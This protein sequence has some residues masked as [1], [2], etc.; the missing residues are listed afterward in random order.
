MAQS[1]ETSERGTEYAQEYRVCRAPSRFV[2]L[3]GACTSD[4]LVN[5][6]S[7]YFIR[8]AR[9]NMRTWRASNDRSFFGWHFLILRWV[10]A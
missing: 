1:D 2:L 3:S 8:I 4:K 10:L 9:K 5:R 6:S 7:N